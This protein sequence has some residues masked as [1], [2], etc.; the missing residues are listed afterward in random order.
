MRV[1]KKCP[2]AGSNHGPYDLQSYA[3]P[4]ELQ[5]QSIS[6]AVKS[7][8]WVS[9]SQNDHFHFQFRQHLNQNMQLK[10]Y[11][12]SKSLSSFKNRR[13]TSSTRFVNQSAL[14]KRFKK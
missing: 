7:N 13:K 1:I 4:A 10:A 6:I 14:R 8:K 9:V 3:L 2:R 5:G 11:Q 12:T